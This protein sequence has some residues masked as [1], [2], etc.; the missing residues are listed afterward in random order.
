MVQGQRLK[1]ALGSEHQC[2]YNMVMGYF[3][4]MEDE[5]KYPDE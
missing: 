2:Q 4:D 3:S 1:E 5:N